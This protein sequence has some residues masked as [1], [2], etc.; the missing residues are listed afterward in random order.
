ML[1]SGSQRANEVQQLYC[2]ERGFAILD[3]LDRVAKPTTR[4][5]QMA[6]AWIMARPT[7]TAAL[8]SAVNRAQV[9]DIVRASEIAL[10]T[11]SVNRLNSVSD[12]PP[13]LSRT[14]A[15]VQGLE[16]PAHMA[17]SPPPV[18]DENA[19]RPHAPRGTLRGRLA[20]GYFQ[21]RVMK[22]PLRAPP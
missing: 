8:A 16:V 2:N 9:T 11:E 6:L 17:A 10:D 15:G 22:K 3:E 5:A 13:P 4:V 20:A 14:R 12:T 21:I 7:I 1:E 18:S 19:V